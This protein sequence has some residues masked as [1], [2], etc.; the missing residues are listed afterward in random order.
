MEIWDLYTKDGIKT[1]GTARRGATLPQDRFHLV[2]HFWLKNASGDYLIQ[3][4]SD[5]VES[6]PGW[7]AI[8][9]GS[10]IRGDDSRSA[11]LREVDE[12]IGLKISDPDRLLKIRRYVKRQAIIDV[13]MLEEDAG[14]DQFRIGEE[15]SEI[16]FRNEAAIRT[17]V[18]EKIF[19]DYGA[20]YF[21]LVFNFR[22]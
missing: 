21:D 14:P 3:K 12:E 4:R 10:A 7:W 13:W 1:G 19:W 6:N 16:A 17:M 15:V 20:A 11:V 22:P 18:K 5:R 8:T 9:G 2:V